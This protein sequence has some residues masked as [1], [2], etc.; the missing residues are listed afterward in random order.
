MEKKYKVG[1]YGVGMVGGSLRRYFESKPN[2]EVFIYDKK[3]LGSLEELN[4]A[5][6]IYVALPTPYVPEKGCDTSIIED[7][8]KEIKGNKVIIIKSTVTPGTVD[9]LQR[10]YDNHK[11]LFN[12]E[13]LTE[14]T[15]DNDM[16]YPDRQIIGYTK[17]SY[18][19]SKDILQQ[20][21]LAPYERIVPAIVAEFIKYGTNTLL[22]I[23]NSA[24]NELY[25]LAKKVGL[26][27]DE[28]EE[29]VSGIACDKR[30]GRTHMTVIHK[31]KRGYW[32]KC[33]PKD[34]KALIVFAKKNG[35]NLPVREATNQY[36]DKLLNSQGIKEYV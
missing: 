28:W 3:G 34:M 14:L 24:T 16:A 9:K 33:L 31:G 8:I 17:Q 11:F 21:P 18:T 15:A 6:F 26:S 2:Y 36:N 23:K 13:F 30:I 19:I 29:L 4:Q 1:I 10:I 12:P 22:A 27:E 35:V 20:L 5:D 7:A 32:G 25:D